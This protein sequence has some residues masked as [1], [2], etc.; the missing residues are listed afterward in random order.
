[1][2]HG[3]KCTDFTTENVVSAMNLMKL[4]RERHCYLSVFVGK[5]TVIFVVKDTVIFQ[6]CIIFLSDLF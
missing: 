5:D 2:P 6:N 1:M 3:R 4:L